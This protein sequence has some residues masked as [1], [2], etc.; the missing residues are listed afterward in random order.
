MLPPYDE[1]NGQH[2]IEQAHPEERDPNTT[3]HWHSLPEQA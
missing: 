3:V 2:I 1:N